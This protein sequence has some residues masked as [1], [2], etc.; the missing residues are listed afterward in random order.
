MYATASTHC[1][2]NARAA[3]A[4]RTKGEAGVGAGPLV[5]QASLRLTIV[6][7]LSFSPLGGLSSSSFH[8]LFFVQL[9]S[10]TRRLDGGFQCFW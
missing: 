3:S 2:P 4:I 7:V 5:P 9:V 6:H 1:D 8:N 10:V